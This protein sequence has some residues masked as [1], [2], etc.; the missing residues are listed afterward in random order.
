MNGSADDNV[1][2]AYLN[3]IFFDQDMVYKQ[4]GFKQIS[5]AADFSKEYVEFPTD[6]VAPEIGFIYC[7]LSMESATGRVFWDDFKV[8]VNEHPVVQRSDY[9]PFGMQMAG[10]YNRITVYKNQFLFNQGL[11]DEKFMTER[12]TD[13][14]L[15]LDMT[16]HRWYDYSIGRFMQIDPLSDQ[17]NQEVLT[18]YQFSFN[19]PIL[20]SDPLGLMGG[21]PRPGPGRRGV[22]VRRSGGNRASIREAA[23]R[24]AAIRNS[25][26]SALG[27]GP[28][29]GSVTRTSTFNVGRGT[30]SRAN[31]RSSFGRDPKGATND[32]EHAFGT[33]DGGFAKVLIRVKETVDHILD[34]ASSIEVSESFIE[35]NGSAFSLGESITVDDGGTTKLLSDLQSEFDAAVHQSAQGDLSDEEW[36]NLDSTERSG[37]LLGAYFRAGPSPTQQVRDRI[38][39]SEA[40]EE[41]VQRATVVRSN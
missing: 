10:G 14:G 32:R 19:N 25:P 33:K 4:S 7:F 26:V 11:G 31:P 13:L 3:Y 20:Y 6:I 5:G 24:A 9:Y 40:D 17:G 39:N 38:K 2:A 37:R 41:E 21:P 15:N 22:R 23:A 12:I 28:L 29:G 18:P 35:S 8:T 1:P 36:Q 16:K 27:R 34:N 30:G